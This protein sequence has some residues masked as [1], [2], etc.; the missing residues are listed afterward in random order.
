MF[1]SLLASAAEVATGPE[2]KR[3]LTG[4]QSVCKR[5]TPQQKSTRITFN[6]GSAADPFESVSRLPA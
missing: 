1:G 4:F 3:K 5:N 6:L 2:A